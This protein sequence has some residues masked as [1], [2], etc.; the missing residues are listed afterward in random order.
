Q[1][2]SQYKTFHHGL[3]G[4]TD[5]VH[6]LSKSYSEIDQ[7]TKGIADGTNE[8]EKGARQLHEGSTELR[9]ETKDLPN[10]MQSEIDE[11]LASFDYSDFE[12]T[13]FVSEKNDKIGVVQFVLQTEKIENLDDEDEVDEKT[14]EKGFWQRFLDLFRK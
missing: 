7:G 12:A 14:E 4:Y 5:G 10:E 6:Q 11:Q 2:S 8:L 1:L 3:V 9:E 13:S